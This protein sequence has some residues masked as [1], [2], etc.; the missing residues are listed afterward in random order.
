[1]TRKRSER[2]RRSR[3]NEP[4]LMSEVARELGIH[5]VTAYEHARDGKLPV[6]WRGGRYEM[7]RCDL[8]RLIQERKSKAHHLSHNAVGTA[9]SERASARRKS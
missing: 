1:M 8:D 5:R 2:D 4:A 9:S 3:S 7:R 6:R